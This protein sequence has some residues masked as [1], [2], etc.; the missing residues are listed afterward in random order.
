M[1]KNF[2]SSVWL[3]SFQFKIKITSAA[4]S[5]RSLA[6]LH[7]WLVHALAPRI[8]RRLYSRIKLHG[9]IWACYDIIWCQDTISSSGIKKYSWIRT[10][11]EYFVHCLFTCC[12]D[13]KSFLRIPVWVK[14]D[15]WIALIS[16]CTRLRQGC[17]FFNTWH[18]VKA[19]SIRFHIL[20]KPCFHGLIRI[21]V[22]LMKDGKLE[23]FDWLF[24]VI[25]DWLFQMLLDSYW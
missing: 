20:W 25:L 1:K 2:F 5:L 11:N 14:T 4:F 3:L 7:L 19:S 22:S 23:S 10:C 8:S 24:W 15:K 18:T 9:L 13:E 12:L 16:F 17:L 6:G 21:M